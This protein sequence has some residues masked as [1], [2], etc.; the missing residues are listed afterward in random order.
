MT[1]F[2]DV[3]LWSLGALLSFGAAAVTAGAVFGVVA[4]ALGRFASYD[5][6]GRWMTPGGSH[7]Y[8]SIV[9]VI[10]CSG[11]VRWWPLEV[12]DFWVSVLGFG[13]T[14]SLRRVDE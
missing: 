10:S 2:I 7:G 1:G 14:F 13:F 5:M 8:W 4:W 11:E 12:A 6:E 9:D 3:F